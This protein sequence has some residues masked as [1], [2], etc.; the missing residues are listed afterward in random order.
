MSLLLAGCGGD[1]HGEKMSWYVVQ[2]YSS[3][4]RQPAKAQSEQFDRTVAALKKI[5]ASYP[6]WSN[7]A[8]LQYTLGRMYGE[9]GDIRRAE[10]E[11]SRVP[12]SFPKDIELGARALFAAGQL[13]E[14]NGQWNR[15]LGY[16]RN[17]I[18]QYPKTLTGIQLPLYIARHYQTQM[19]SSQAQKAYTQ[20]VLFYN[21]VIDE[22]PYDE[23]VFGVESLLVIAYANQGKWDAA[24]NAL[25]NVAY[26][27]P[28]SSAASLSLF[29]A[30]MICDTALQKPGKAIELYKR[31]IVSY[32]KSTIGKNAKLEIANMSIMQ[33]DVEKAQSEFYDII[34]HDKQ[35]AP[36]CATAHLLLASGYDKAGRWNDALKEYNEIMKTYPTS[37]E[38]FRVP[39]LIA[40][41]YQLPRQQVEKR[42]ILRKGIMMYKR[43]ISINSEPSI[44]A[45]AWDF[46][47]EAYGML[48]K[49][50]EAI[51]ALETLQQKFPSDPHAELVLL[52]LGMFYQQGLQNYKKAAVCY[53]QFLRERPEHRLAGDVRNM[54]NNLKV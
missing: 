24:E 39:L 9:R 4:I 42:E 27:Y 34:D 6:S 25:E 28:K 3:V 29:R 52:R 37:I 26:K 5:I 44:R 53:C 7:C 50:K 12:L 51:S 35:D 31:I 22:N 54:L 18:S 41:H 11:Y 47:A 2:R 36:V 43:N 1:Y 38:S 40:L 13:Y 8:T 48:G 23:R 45:A 19:N 15:A 49:W 46:M 14:H 17:V 10:E 21:S 20:A 16:Y 32:P 33:G 30:A